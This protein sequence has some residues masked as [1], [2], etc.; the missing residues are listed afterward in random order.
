MEFH[1]VENGFGPILGK[2]AAEQMKLIT[3]NYENICNVVDIT[4]D[5]SDVFS[6]KIGSLPGLV[7]LTID[8]SVTPV[9]V[10]S[11]R[12]PL[13]L[14][15]K[16]KSELCKLESAGV[17]AKVDRP[18]DWVNRMVVGTKKSGDLRICIDP[19]ALNKA[20]KRELYPLP[21]LDDILPK[22]SKARVFSCFD[23]KHGYWHCKLDEESSYL[24]T[25]QTPLGR[26]RWLK[27]P[28]GMAVSSEIF[29]KKLNT[30]L[31]GLDGV[32]CVADDILV[33]G[34]GENDD[35]ANA[36]HDK[37][38]RKLLERCQDIGIVLNRSKT[39]L[40]TSEISFLGH[41]ISK[42]GIKPDP[43]K[44]KAITMLKAPTNVT[45]VQRLSGMV[46]YLA[47]FLP[48][49]SDVME[50]IRRLT[51]KDVEWNWGEEQKSAFAEVKKLV[52]TSSV[53]AFYD[54]AKPLEIQCDA[55]QTGLGAVLMQEGKPIHYASRAL[56]PTETRYAQIEKE[57][58]AV[59]FAL[60]K[61]HQYTFGRVTKIRSDHKP[62]QAIL[63]KPIDRAPRRLQGMLMRAYQY[64]IELEYQPGKSMHIAD[65]LSRNFLPESGGGQ[66]FESI[67][68][69]SFLPVRP[70]TIEKIQKATVTD[71]IMQLLSKTI[72]EGWPE[73][74][75]KVPNQILP[76][77]TSRDEF[78]VQN[79]LIFKGERVLIPHDLRYEIKKAIHAS[80]I[81]IEG[82]LRRARECVY[83][84]GMNAEVKEYIAHC[85]TCNKYNTNQHKE[86]L[87]PH[88]TGDRPW[89]KVG[90]DIFE[91]K[92]QNFLITVDYFSNFWEVDV[93]DSP[94]ASQ[95]IRKLKAHFARYGI[96]SVL[97]SDNGSQFVGE[98]FQTF[99]KTY[100]FDHKTSSPRYPQS[101][102]MAESAVK[103]AKNLLMKA[104][105]SGRDP[106]LAIL[107]Y[108]NTPSQDS[109]LSPAQRS[110]GRRTRTLLPMSS[111]LLQPK[112]IDT[113][114]E[115]KMNKLK[116]M[117]SAWYHDRTA[118]DL[119]P[120]NEGDTVRI[121]PSVLGDKHWKKGTVSKRLD[122]RS[123]EVQ[124]DGTTVRRNR[125]H[126][127][128]SVECAPWY[129]WIGDRSGTAIRGR[130]ENDDD[131]EVQT[132]TTNP[133]NARVNMPTIPPV[134]TS[135]RM[136]VSHSEPT[137][138]SYNLR[139]RSQ[140]MVPNRF[141]DY[142]LNR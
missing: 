126:L 25:F 73:D 128:K 135:V 76:Y 84:P 36:D 15:E 94:R 50:P 127:R 99:A 55:S 103:T 111:R 45:D 134:D 19:Q 35:A 129:K 71:E 132:N 119:V 125:L 5:F 77:F 121:K 136:N 100:E 106:Y 48:K 63:K 6:D 97:I 59:V 3:V 118:K 130:V 93:L 38:V 21:L 51:V 72:T 86:T 29:Q 33:Y 23:L 22:L 139:S 102:G 109:G 116:N 44:V 142:I 40:K 108:R 54:P 37:K 96:P 78:S 131:A 87:I 123:Y 7:H 10:N 56:T 140:R 18:T 115:K 67:N 82:C 110:L 138:A 114:V 117:K 52:T 112:G 90:V 80:H 65:L 62:L 68:M 14:Q 12:V 88:D 133:V 30:A 57:M 41:K 107:D 39:S 113:T 81:G 46:N 137:T 43:D 58:L 24:T 69:V 101:N 61:F 74:R 27:V 26:Y 120:L 124:V 17:I 98:A 92:N 13:S 104:I 32:F 89:D 70:T 20:L 60:T 11:C 2:K 53:L 42:D 122:E 141:K 9:A 64:H 66:I 91:L 8:P 105:D 95:V 28:F 47:R 85:E 34:E 31:E 79:G 83:W 16:V 1:V 4:N 49:L 75:S